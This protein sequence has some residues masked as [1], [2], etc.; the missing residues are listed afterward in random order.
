MDPSDLDRLVIGSTGTAQLVA[1]GRH[2]A[3]SMGSGSIEVFSTPMMVALME[4]AAVDCV[5]HLLPE[6]MV[7]L[8][9]HLDVSHVAATPMGC[10]IRATAR[11]HSRE[12]R[13]LEF[14]V[15]A[16]DGQEVIGRGMHRRAVVASD[17]FL[18]RL[19]AKTPRSRG[20]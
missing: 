17:R 14:A 7:S 18:A 20:S 12:G 19:A 9:T 13:N 2:S 6:G 15:E 5:E 16:H 3:R 10:S 1:E 11:L 4:A 8:G